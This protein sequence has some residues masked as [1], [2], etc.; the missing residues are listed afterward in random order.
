MLFI[1][2]DF[3]RHRGFETTQLVN[4]S[5]KLIPTC[6]LYQ[7]ACVQQSFANMH[8]SQWLHMVYHMQQ[9]SLVFSPSVSSFIRLEQL[10]GCV[11]A[12]AKLLYNPVG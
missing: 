4:I 12:A 8:K 10:L 11:G 5:I 9:C 1:T 2:T 3:A 7:L 6:M